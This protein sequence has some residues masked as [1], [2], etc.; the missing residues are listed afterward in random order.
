MG[1]PF[2]LRE[3]VRFAP[4]GRREAENPMSVLASE[5]RADLNHTSIRLQ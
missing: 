1:G 2:F 3:L 5:T 4:E